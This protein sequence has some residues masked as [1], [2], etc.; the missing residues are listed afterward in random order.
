[1][2]VARRNV[3]LDT[4]FVIALEKKDDPHHAAAGRDTQIR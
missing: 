3:F 2:I 4:S 1:L